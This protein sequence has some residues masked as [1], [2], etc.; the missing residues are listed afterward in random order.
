MNK[1]NLL[2][3]HKLI[4][5]RIIG[6]DKADG[7]FKGGQNHHIIYRVYNKQKPLILRYVR[8]RSPQMAIDGLPLLFNGSFKPQWVTALKQVW[9]NGA[10][11]GEKFIKELYGD[12]Q[13]VAKADY[14]DYADQFL[15]EHAGSKI[16]GIM[17]TDQTWLANTIRQGVD[18]G[19]T[20]PQIASSLTYQFDNMSVGRAGTI[21]RTETAS[22]F[23]YA[24]QQTATDLMPDGSTKTW[25]TTS[26][27]PRPWHEDADGQTVPIDEPFIVMDEEMDFPGDSN[28]SEANVINCLCVVSY[29]Y[30]KAA[31][32]E[33]NELSPEEEESAL[34]EA[35]MQL[36]GEE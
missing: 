19:L 4:M 31:G 7:T 26:D 36:G 5:N 35:S 18:E 12:V 16:D 6:R 29:D 28:G 21:A 11:E 32:E 25:N 34:S 3:R 23:N 8:S 24:S 20:T 17:D 1:T 22:A 15:A 27:K 30:S 13:K 14:Q 10:E 9:Q 2:H 33:E